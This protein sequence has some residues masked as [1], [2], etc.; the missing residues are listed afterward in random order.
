MN[1]I[2]VEDEQLLLDTMIE[3][4]TELM[5]DALVIGF[6]KVYDA[7][8]FVKANTT[9]IAIL[10]IHLTGNMNGINLGEQLRE[11]DDNIKL[12]FCTGYSDYALDAFKIHANAYLCKPILK[13]DLKRELEYVQKLDR[14]DITEKPRIHTFGNFDLFVN[15]RPVLFRRS[16]SKEVLAYLTDREGSWVTNR[17]LI[18][19]LWEDQSTDMFF[20]KYISTLVRDMVKDLRAVGAEHIIERQRG[21]VRLLRDKVSC[22]YYDYLDSD[23]QAMAKFHFEYMSQYSWGEVTLAYLTKD[24]RDRG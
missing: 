18:V 9:D 5:P 2:I 4:T 17:E 11:L 16:K 13:E 19:A 21:R 12:I 8:E 22:D 1:I 15:G 14:T 10:D 24:S 6:S 7:L 20:V 23:S 3:Y